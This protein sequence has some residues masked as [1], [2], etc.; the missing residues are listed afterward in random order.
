[1][2]INDI[3][4]TTSIHFQQLEMNFDSNNKSNCRYPSHSHY[5]LSSSMRI[6]ERERVV[7]GATLSSE[8]RTSVEKDSL[9]CVLSKR[10]AD[11]REVF[12]LV[13]FTLVLIERIDKVEFKNR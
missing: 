2:T 1:M 7:R 9:L 12:T 11:M 4:V 6:D 13:V 3:H 8:T 10:A 5:V